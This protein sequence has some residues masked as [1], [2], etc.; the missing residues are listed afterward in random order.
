MNPNEMDVNEMKARLAVRLLGAKW[1]QSPKGHVRLVVDDEP[2]I[3]S[4]VLETE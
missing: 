1:V 2:G 4:T 3:G